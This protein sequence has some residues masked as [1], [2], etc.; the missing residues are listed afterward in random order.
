MGFVF[1]FINILNTESLLDASAFTQNIDG[2][3]PAHSSYVYKNLN[4]HH[5]TQK[6]NCKHKYFFIQTV[7][8]W[9]RVNFSEKCLA[10][11]RKNGYVISNKNRSNF[12]ISFCRNSLFTWK[13]V[14]FRILRKFILQFVL[15]SLLPLYIF[16]E[17]VLKRNL[18]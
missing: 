17:V 9:W 7:M 10:L 14:S 8:S 13:Q 16:S 4:S 15:I 1:C 2:R 12:K 3:R 5:S 18:G 6:K 11:K